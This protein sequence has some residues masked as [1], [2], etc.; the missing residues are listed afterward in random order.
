MGVSTNSTVLGSGRRP[1][2][3]QASVL[4]FRK[5]AKQTATIYR[6]PSWKEQLGKEGDGS[7]MARAA[8][9]PVRAHDRRQLWHQ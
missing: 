2:A 5:V 1:Q 7:M 6:Y 9:R 3:N 4:P 8:S